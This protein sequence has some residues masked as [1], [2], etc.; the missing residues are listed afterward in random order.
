MLGRQL[1]YPSFEP[2]T[3]YCNPPV[4]GRIAFLMHISK[5]DGIRDPGSAPN[6]PGIRSQAAANN[7]P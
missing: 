3:Y 2:P 4:I 6:A 1:S 5:R 7:A